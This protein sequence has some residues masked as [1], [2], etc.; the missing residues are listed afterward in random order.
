MSSFIC[1]EC[2]SVSNYEDLSKDVD[3]LLD[4]CHERRLE[5]EQPPLQSYFR[6]YAIL[7]VTF[8]DKYN[9]K[10]STLIEGTNS[11]ASFIQH[12]IC[13]ERSAMSSVAFRRIINPNIEKVIISTDS[14]QPISPGCLC[15]QYMASFSHDPSQTMCYMTNADRSVTASTTLRDLYPY[16]FLYSRMDR[17]LIEIFIQQYQINTATTTTTMLS[18]RQI[19]KKSDYG[20]KLLQSIYSYNYSA[21]STNSGDNNKHS[22]GSRSSSGSCSDS[23]SDSLE[24]IWWHD[25]KEIALSTNEINN[26]T[27][28]TN[29]TNTSNTNGTNGTTNNTNNTNNGALVI[30]NT[31]TACYANLMKVLNEGTCKSNESEVNNNN[32]VHPLSYAGTYCTIRNSNLSQKCRL[33]NVLETNNKQGSTVNMESIFSVS[34]AKHGLEYGCTADPLAVFI[35][36]SDGDDIKKSLQSDRS[37]S[38]SS[39]MVVFIQADNLG[40]CHAPFAQARALMTEHG[41]DGCYSLVHVPVTSDNENNTW[42]DIDNDN[43]D[44]NDNGDITLELQLV[45]MNLMVPPLDG[46]YHGRL[47]FDSDTFADN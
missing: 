15:R 7:V 36:S 40:I 31:I 9:K 14:T 23:S 37:N 13:A 1:R 26:T 35:A 8:Y 12:S 3:K 41:F 16:Q 19:I 22:K 27:N 39:N 29:T 43:N 46:G 45:R 18:D 2:N 47:C 21:I 17:K 28:T 25:L 6:V 4:L 42:S 11:E 32:D 30:I 10:Q 38:H 33:E 24:W 44:N 20:P 34:K 5:L